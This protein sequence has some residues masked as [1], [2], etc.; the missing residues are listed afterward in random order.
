MQHQSYQ[1]D[2]TGLHNLAKHIIFLKESSDAALLMAKEV[3][4]HHRQLVV[5]T[6]SP[7]NDAAA[8]TRTNATQQML[9]H[10]VTQFQSV[11]LRLTTLENRM[12][13][14]INLVRDVGIEFLSKHPANL[15]AFSTSHSI[16][17]C[18]KIVTL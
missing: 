3:C 2:F 17:P 15:Y 18:S 10:K 12:Q 14:V 5:E 11:C 6:A 9:H 7:Q 13:N 16:L 8:P 4:S 1:Q